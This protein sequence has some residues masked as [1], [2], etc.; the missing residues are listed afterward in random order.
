[1]TEEIWKPFNEW[2]EVSTHGRVRSWKNNRWGR[3]LE[4][5]NLSTP[6]SM[7]GYPHLR[8]EGKTRFVHHLVLEVFVGP[9]PEGKEACHRNGIRTDNRLENLYW[10]TRSENV[11]DAIK[12][13][14][15]FWIAK[16][17]AEH[18][19]KRNG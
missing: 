13:G 8:V 10:G 16:H 19:W 1:M 18:G 17:V 15:H 9:M 2:Y 3:R 4:P 6:L 12:H 14:T 11:Q 5:K 7:Y